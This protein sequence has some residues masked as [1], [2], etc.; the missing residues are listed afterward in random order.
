MNDP[1]TGLNFVELSHPWGHGTPT[2]PGYH[3]VVLYRGV[4]HATHGVMSHRVRMT[5][6]SSTHVNA[7]IHLVAGGRGV[8]EIGLDHFFGQGVVVT[9]PKTRWELVT[10]EDLEAAKPNIETGDIVLINTGWHHRYSDSQEYFGDAPGLSPAAAQWLVNRRVK[11]VGMDTPQID[12]PLATSL[13]P[14]RNGPRMNRLP[15][16]YRRQTGREPRDDFPDWNPAHRLL[17]ENDIPTIENVGGE[18][19]SM[20]ASRCTLHAC[21]WRWLNG[22]ACV[23][24]LVAIVDPGGNYRLESGGG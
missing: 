17:L 20:N 14:Q 12:H 6:H 2:L 7:P 13:G 3:E 24:R 18:L 23:V 19:D 9:A 15:D 10:V 11:L 21:P 1:A 8:G 16:R 4:N 5:M 22:D